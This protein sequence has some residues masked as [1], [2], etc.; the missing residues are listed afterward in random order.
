MKKALSQIV[1]SESRRSLSSSFLNI[2]KST[3]PA[4][5]NTKI[6]SFLREYREIEEPGGCPYADKIVF[7][8]MLHGV[9]TKYQKEISSSTFIDLLAFSLPD[10]DLYKSLNAADYLI[11]SGFITRVEMRDMGSFFEVIASNR[12]RISGGRS[13]MEY[14]VVIEKMIVHVYIKF[15]NGEMLGTDIQDAING[16]ERF[17]ELF[18]ELK[19]DLATELKKELIN[20]QYRIVSSD[21]SKDGGGSGNGERPNKN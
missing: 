7:D 20:E 12:K 1:I 4:D 13:A 2:Y 17:E 14:Q 19:F 9:M 8:E 5:L 3:S 10:S 15:K 21:S 18:R 6:S 16:I 11:R